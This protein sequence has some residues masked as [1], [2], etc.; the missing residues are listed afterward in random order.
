MAAKFEDPSIGLE[1]KGQGIPAYDP[2]GLKGMGIAYATS[3]QGA[4]HLALT[5]R[6]LNWV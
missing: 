4:C 1:V 5:L 3:N 6:P 2:R